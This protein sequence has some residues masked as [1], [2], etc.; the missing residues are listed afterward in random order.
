MECPS[1]TFQNTP[2]TASC[3]RCSGRLDFS[4]VEITPPRAGRHGLSRWARVW[5]SIARFRLGNALADLRTALMAD[6]RA[7]V[8][9][10]ALALSIIPGAGQWAVGQRVLGTLLFLVWGVLLAASTLFIGTPYS[11]MLGGAIVGWHCLAVN[12]IARPALMQRPVMERAGWGLVIWIC[13]LVCVYTP[14]FIL[15]RRCVGWVG[16]EG[17]R[18]TQT[19][20]QGDVIVYAGRWFKPAQWERGDLVSYVMRG[21]I[22]PTFYIRAGRGV[23]RIIALPGDEVVYSGN[24]LLVNGVAPPAAQRPL[25]EWPAQGGTRFIVPE[26]R[27]VIVPSTLPLQANAT[28]A[29]RSGQADTLRDLITVDEQD[30][31]GRVLWRTR[32]WARFGP[33]EDVPGPPA[34]TGATP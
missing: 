4:G 19:L 6:D 27:V 12:L 14:G 18:Y 23:D 15:L 5:A 25:L 7:E 26:G 29:P 34:P 20:R 32:P 28:S 8:S 11:Y 10:V 22:G 16:I 17:I 21:F 1:C 9:R 30:I 31:S 3:V 33:V 2:G 13:L 24:A